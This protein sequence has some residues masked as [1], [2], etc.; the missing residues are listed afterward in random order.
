LGEVDGQPARLETVVVGADVV[1][2]GA[3]VGRRQFAG[4][5]LLHVEALAEDQGL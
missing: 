3:V 5:G 4:N 1:H 2:D